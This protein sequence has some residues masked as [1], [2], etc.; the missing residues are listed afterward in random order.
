MYWI[1]SKLYI[2]LECDCSGV[3]S[4]HYTGSCDA[5]TT[6]IIE[7]LEISMWLIFYLYYMQY[8][9]DI[10]AHQAGVESVLE[11]DWTESDK[12]TSEN[13]EREKVSEL[14]RVLERDGKGASKKLTDGSQLTDIM[15][16]DMAHKEYGEAHV[17]LHTNP[18]SSKLSDEN[19]DSKEDGQSNKQYQ[20]FDKRSCWRES[21]KKGL[22]SKGDWKH[23][24]PGVK[25]SPWSLG[26][27]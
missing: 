11:R 3:T 1:I 6:S 14:T 25:Q 13:A 18:L 16:K 10:N 22:H 23:A 5:S 19:L 26:S 4:F 17:E 9:Q 12:K 8:L 7:V 15:C 27:R 20:A 21:D 24:M 2:C